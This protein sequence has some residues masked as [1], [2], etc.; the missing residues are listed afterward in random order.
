MQSDF[1]P[2]MPDK[3]PPTAYPNVPKLLEMPH[4]DLTFEQICTL[5]AQHRAD[6][7]GADGRP[8]SSVDTDIPN[9]PDNTAADM[10]SAEPAPWVP[11]PTTCR[12]LAAW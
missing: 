9:F 5:A 1:V 4:D 8:L 7:L 6:A 12:L 10:K 2:F 11:R 3:E